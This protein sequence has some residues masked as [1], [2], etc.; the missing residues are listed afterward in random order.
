MT[1]WYIM[2]MAIFMWKPTWRKYSNRSCQC[3]PC[4]KRQPIMLFF[5]KFGNNQFDEASSSQLSN[6]ACPNTWL[7]KTLTS[8]QLQP[9]IAE[10]CPAMVTY[11]PSIHSPQYKNIILFMFLVLSKLILVLSKLILKLVIALIWNN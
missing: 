11:S 2:I 5:A 10:L 8:V 1:I 9:I 6:K 7:P 3:D 4:I